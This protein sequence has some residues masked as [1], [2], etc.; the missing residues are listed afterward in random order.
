[1]RKIPDEVTAVYPPAFD[2]PFPGR[3]WWTVGG[4]F[5]GASRWD[6]PAQ[7]ILEITNEHGGLIPPGI[8]AGFYVWS[9]AQEPVEWTRIPDVA[10]FEE[11]VAKWDRE[12]PIA[13]PAFRVGQVWARADG[14]ARVIQG[15]L[16]GDDDG[17]GAGGP[18]PVILSPRGGIRMDTAM[19]CFLLADPVC[20]WSAPWA[21]VESRSDHGVRI[22]YVPHEHD[23]RIAV[24]RAVRRLTGCGLSEA[25]FVADSAPF[26]L[27]RAACATVFGPGTFVGEPLGV[28]DLRAFVAEITA[29]NA[30][31]WILP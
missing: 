27:T 11:A 10:T 22:E 29:V 16:D 15:F 8:T 12:H 19:F 31:A 26:T 30:T 14:V 1:M 24:I 23:A 2:R 7:G 25:K 9:P 13:R 4:R 18:W 21:P 28:D 5:S 6:M 20:P 17:D 3:P